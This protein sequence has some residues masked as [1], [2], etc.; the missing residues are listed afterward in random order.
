MKI[1]FHPGGQE[2][3]ADSGLKLL[4]VARKAKTGIRFGCGACGCGTCGVRLLEGKARPM[5]APEK[6][7][8]EKMYL[9]VDGTIRLACQA[10]VHEDD[11]VVDLDFQQQYSPD[12]GMI[13]S[14][15]PS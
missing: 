3:D 12:R 4:V 10:K 11:L 8:L 7:L 5:D 9:P 14:D 6:A 2:V 1:K 13:E 15:E